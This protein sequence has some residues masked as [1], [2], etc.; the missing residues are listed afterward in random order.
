MEGTWSIRDLQPIIV[1]KRK[2]KK[3]LKATRQLLISI[4]ET[5]EKTLLCIFFMNAILMYS[6]LKAKQLFVAEAD[7]SFGE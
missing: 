1:R 7:D 4:Q 6:T 2:E 3:T 5:G